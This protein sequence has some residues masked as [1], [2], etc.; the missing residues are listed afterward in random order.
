MAI[1]RGTPLPFT[2]G[3]GDQGMGLVSS[4]C[5]G[6]PYLAQWTVTG[7]NLWGDYLDSS[8]IISTVSCPGS[9][10]TVD[11]NMFESF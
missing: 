9:Y 10:T 8:E 11:S 5:P 7:N 2:R 6:G 3:G 1:V 4:V